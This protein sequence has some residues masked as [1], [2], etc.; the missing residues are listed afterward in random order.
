[1]EKR[2]R[3]KQQKEEEGDEF[4]DVLNSGFL[5]Y[6]P[7]YDQ[8]YKHQKEGLVFLYKAYESKRNGVI[9]ADDMGL[10]KTIQI[11]TFLSGMLDTYKIRSVLLVMPN[12][13]MD[14]WVKELRKWTP[15]M[16][17]EVY[18]SSE[19]NREEKLQMVQKN[20]DV[21]ITSYRMLL[22]NA[23]KFSTSKKKTFTWDCVI[24]DEVHCIKNRSSKCF[25]AAYSIPAKTRFLL[26]GTPL[27]NNLEEMWSLYHLACQGRLLGTYPTFKKLYEVPI[28]RGREKDASTTERALG[29]KISENLNEMLKPYYLRRTK[30]DLQRKAQEPDK[31]N[32]HPLDTVKMPKFTR[33][34]DFVVWIPISPLQEY[35]Y[36]KLL[37]TRTSRDHI[38]HID[39][40]D[41]NTLKKICDHPR[42]LSATECSDLELEDD[43]KKDIAKF[44]HSRK[45]CISQLSSESLMEESGKLAFLV[46]LLERL[47]EEGNRTLVFS[48]SLKMLDII[49]YILDERGFKTI[50][51]DGSI[52]AVDARHRLVTL[53]QTKKDYS[54]FLLTSQVG[55]VGLN[56]TAANRV[57][58]VN[59]SWNPASDDQA[60]DRV[61][62]I[63]QEKDVV[64]YRLI[65]CGTV[66]EKIYRRQVF[67]NS[68]IKQII[69]DDKNPIRYFSN[70]EL[71]E[72]FTLESTQSSSTQLQLQTLH[73][74]Q[75]ETYKALDDN[76]AYLHTL[77]IFGISDHNLL[78]STALE[79]D[80]EKASARS[81]IHLQVQKAQQKIEAES[82]S[83]KITSVSSYGWEVGNKK[84]KEKKKPHQ[85]I[86]TQK[87]FVSAD[88]I[89][90]RQKN[91]RKRQYL[92]DSRHSSS[93]LTNETASWIDDK[94]QMN[95]V[96]SVLDTSGAE[97]SEEEGHSLDK[98]ES[99]VCKLTTKFFATDKND[100]SNL[101]PERTLTRNGSREAGVKERDSE[102]IED[103]KSVH[104]RKPGSD[105][106]ELY[107]PIPKSR[108]SDSE[109]SVEDSSEINIP[110]SSSAEPA[111]HSVIT[112]SDDSVLSDGS[113]H[114]EPLRLPVLCDY[115]LTPGCISILESE[116]ESSVVWTK[117]TF[118]YPNYRINGRKERTID[119]MTDL[120]VAGDTIKS[121]QGSFTK[122]GFGFIMSSTPVP[123]SKWEAS[124]HRVGNC[125][126]VERNR[127][128]TLEQNN[129]KAGLNDNSKMAAGLGC[130]VRPPV[131]CDYSLTPGSLSMALMERDQ[132]LTSDETKVASSHTLYR[133]DARNS[134]SANN[135]TT[136][137]GSKLTD[138]TKTQAPL[139]LPTLCDYSLT[140]SST[141]VMEASR[142]GSFDVSLDNQGANAQHS[143]MDIESNPHFY[144]ANPEMEFNSNVSKTSDIVET[145]LNKSSDYSSFLGEDLS[146]QP[147]SK[148]IQEGDVSTWEQDD[149]D[150]NESLCNPC[151]NIQ[152]PHGADVSKQ[153]HAS[154]SFAVSTGSRPLVFESATVI[155]K[156]WTHEDEQ[157]DGKESPPKAVESTERTH[158]ANMTG[159]RISE[160]LKLTQKV[161]ALFRQAEELQKAD[162]LND[163]LTLLK[164]AL[165]IKPG[166]DP[167]L[168]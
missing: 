95:S 114:Q 63:G 135:L 118:S 168:T 43:R 61:D 55:G 157:N 143:L 19:K 144:I 75:R 101:F 154:Q 107:S 7:L 159:C 166:S 147:V 163:V 11:V 52:N 139:W 111:I 33:K 65:T 76:L 165:H 112:V 90:R 79:E 103:S 9:L 45:R 117:P 102:S 162:I 116:K 115:S 51:I 140:P 155:S 86:S 57:V 145:Q 120:D 88:I 106:T 30:E 92:Y 78:F 137:D 94:P 13:L 151:Q 161:E 148:G 123:Q 35:I 2:Q 149:K 14:N 98:T 15:H 146:F 71:K 49:D 5:L 53:F 74:H 62:R 67:K 41:V 108:W 34:N 89:Q 105:L 46:P 22:H 164:Q 68:L 39:V 158:D 27:Q 3:K 48:R 87:L 142:C 4:V 26:T 38:D 110:E 47:R 24:F 131:L 136:A 20:G 18:H 82:H 81:R 150:W 58:I 119:L 152:S 127:L 122:P 97:W 25:K 69:G 54:V 31:E 156:E 153:G 84:S 138:C 132:K 44:M 64:I 36:K 17:V 23:S 113:I 66:E 141:P 133:I 99:E 6:K 70:Q 130:T 124:E 1:M 93:F 85:Q 29:Q 125:T 32:Q 37:S 73:C 28:V 96:V 77:K 121:I 60:V 104:F 134:V 83:D 100:D 91:H 10:G 56:L 42:L 59:P 8:L 40:I 126:G 12:G 21:L 160:D 16:N 109:H 50:R 167:R 128:E 129:N 80:L 72:L